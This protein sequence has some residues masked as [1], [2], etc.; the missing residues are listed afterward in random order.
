M[1]QY[2]NVENWKLINYQGHNIKGVYSSLGKVWPTIPSFDGKWLA[3]YSDSHT[4]SA[5]CDST[6][7]ITSGEV[8]K[9]NLVDVQIGNCVTTIGDSAFEE[10][11]TLSSVIILDGVTSIGSNAFYYCY[12]LS[13][14]DIPNS[15]TTIGDSAFEGADTLTSVVIPNSVTSIG[16][17]VFQDCYSLTSVTIGNGIT[18]I[19]RGAFNSCMGLTSIDI[20]SGVTNI[21][22]GAF[23]FCNS[24]TSVTIGNG[25]TSIGDSAFNRCTSLTS[26]DIPSGVTSIGNYAFWNCSG[27][28]SITVEATTPPALA[29]GA[30]D[31]TNDCPIYVP[32]HSVDAY[33][34]A[35]G[36]SNYASRV[37]GVCIFE[38]SLRSGIPSEQCTVPTSISVV[39]SISTAS[40]EDNRMYNFYTS[41]TTLIL[42]GVNVFYGV[43]TSSPN[44]GFQSIKFPDNIKDV[45]AYNGVNYVH[46]NSNN[47]TILILNQG[48]ETIGNYTFR[49][50]NNIDDI[51]HYY[52]TF[53]IPSSVTSIGDN[54]LYF[55]NSWSSWQHKFIFCSATPP[56][57]S[58]KAFYGTDYI[59]SSN[60]HIYI[61]VPSGSKEAYKQKLGG[62]DGF[63]I[64]ELT[65]S[66]FE[67]E[68]AQFNTDIAAQ[69]F[70]SVTYDFPN[71]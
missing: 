40:T 45:S 22:E 49:A 10:A 19:A 1:I 64:Y 68:L 54:A 61:Y 12:S 41:G 21:D 47:K 5:E 38:G 9:T 2:R 67:T 25:V 36:W 13:S 35:S 3:T 59:D 66:S 24:L 23:V 63:T 26:I 18:T 44:Y 52:K 29:F 30:F 14:I 4:E 48:L 15:V 33:K 55:T 51:S 8:A 39:N 17:N 70:E 43:C 11:D 46:D 53:I 65:K 62:G 6:S 7:A 32:C 60:Y 28:T 27:L 31:N 57:M 37:Q 20:P 71:V 34:S 69:G 56:E 58:E 16:T 42:N 50:Y